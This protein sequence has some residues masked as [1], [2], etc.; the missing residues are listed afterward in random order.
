MCTRK[1]HISDGIISLDIKYQQRLKK[2][3]KN[4]TFGIFF[5]K[6]LFKREP[7]K[8]K[9]NNRLRW[10]TEYVRQYLAESII[11]LIVK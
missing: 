11:I 2:K 6:L 7:Y 8:F 5:F 4:K 9:R 3:L 10:T 1:A